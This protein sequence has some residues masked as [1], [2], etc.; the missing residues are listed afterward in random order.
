MGTVVSGLADLSA[1]TEDF[2]VTLIQINET[3]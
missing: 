1:M 2:T 3:T